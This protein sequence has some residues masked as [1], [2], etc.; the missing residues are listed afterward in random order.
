MAI[1]RAK[2][3]LHSAS[4]KL[5]IAKEGREGVALRGRV[6]RGENLNKVPVRWKGRRKVYWHEFSNLEFVDHE[7]DP[8]AYIALAPDGLL[9]LPPIPKP[10]EHYTYN[11]GANLKHFR[12]ERN[13]AQWELAQALAGMGAAVSQTTISYWERRETAPNGEY[14]IALAKAL[15]V[16][17]FLFF[18]NFRDCDWLT[19]VRQYLEQLADIMCEEVVT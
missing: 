17:A 12:Q 14:V 18:I 3:D 6:A 9:D 5:L 19:S 1:V 8:I 13:K 11:F 10:P 2:H 7:L 15:N 4:G 16:P